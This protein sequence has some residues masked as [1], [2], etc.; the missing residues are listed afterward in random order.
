MSYLFFKLIMKLCLFT[1]KN[2]YFPN[3]RKKRKIS[4]NE[5][6]K[7]KIAGDLIVELHTSEPEVYTI[8]LVT[9]IDKVKIFQVLELLLKNLKKGVKTTFED[10]HKIFS[11][12]TVLKYPPKQDQHK[13]PQVYLKQFGY[14]HGDKWYVSVFQKGDNFT[15]QKS[16]KSFTAETNV[17]DIESED[18]RFTRVFESMNGD[19]ENLYHEM[20][21]ELSKNDKVSDKCWEIIVQLTPNI[22]VRSDFWRDF[23]TGILETEH[24]E[25]FLDI[26]LSVHTKSKEELTELK[27]KYFYKVISKEEITQTIINRILIHFMNYFFHHLKR[28]DLV[29]LKAPEGKGFFSSDNPVNFKPN[30]EEGK[31]GM[32][33]KDTEVF[34]PLSDRFLAYFYHKNS[35]QKNPLFR[36]LENRG[37]YNVEDILTDD[38]YKKFINDEIVLS[39]DKL[40][41]FPEKVKS[42]K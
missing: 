17:F 1:D 18:D 35:T 15:R 12:F 39:S 28:F 26:T 16:I 30:Q 8:V 7:V 24:K 36:N 38:E 2:I 5:I 25:T 27:K 3:R 20:L 29:I 42:K 37:I 4:Y 19:L 22:M 23:V 11:E 10:T 21:N 14:Q 34:F 31:L 13:L 40:I 6:T 32:F 41:I 9:A 33:S